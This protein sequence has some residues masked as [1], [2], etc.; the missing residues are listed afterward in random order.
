MSRALRSGGCK[1]EITK[2]KEWEAK[3]R[4]KSRVD[5]IIVIKDLWRRRDRNDVVEEQAKRTIG[6]VSVARHSFDTFSS[7][8]SATKY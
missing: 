7:Q 2:A 8:L 6:N 4:K 5:A 1:Y 3:K